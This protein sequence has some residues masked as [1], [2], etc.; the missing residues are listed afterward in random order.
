MNRFNNINNSAQESDNVSVTS[1]VMYQGRYSSDT[2]QAYDNMENY[3]K[4]YDSS[5]EESISL[6]S[7]AGN[8]DSHHSNNRHLKSL[9][10]LLISDMQSAEEEEEMRNAKPMCAYCGIDNPACIVKCVTCNKWFCNTR[11]G[12]SSSHIINHLVRSRHKIVQLHPNSELGEYTLECYNCGA[13]NVFVLG[14][15][16][17]KADTVMVILCRYPCANAPAQ[18]EMS[19]D[20]SKWTPLIVDRSFSSWL[21][22]A[23]SEEEL[24][25]ARTITPVQMIK[26]EEM[27]RDNPKATIEDLNRPEMENQIPQVSLRYA[28]GYEYQRCFAPLVMHEAEYDRRQK[29]AQTQSNVSVTWDMGL[30]RRHLVSFFLPDFETS[31]IRIMIGDEMAISYEGVDIGVGG[32]KKLK[33]ESTGFVIKVPS[34]SSDDVTLEL[35]PNSDPPTHI[36]SGYSIDFVWSGVTYERI[37]KALKEFAT[38]ETSVSGYLY[39]K[40]L[41]HDVKN[42]VFSHEIPT[43]F[44]VPGISALNPSQSAAVSSVLRHPLS[45]IQGPP[46]TGKT[47]VSTTIVYHI[48]K[49][50]KEAVLVCAP[51][52]VAADQLAVRLSKTGL[53]VIRLVAKSRETTLRDGEA[54]GFSEYGQDNAEASLIKNISLGEIIM[55]DPKT[56]IELKKLQQLK[57]DVG[58]LSVSDRKKYFDLL[59]KAEKRV[60]QQADVVCCT[61]AAAGDPRLKKIRFR[62]VLIDES[63]QA[64][65]PECL[66]PI[67][68]GCKQLVLVGDHQQLGPV[69]GCKA[70]ANA[71]LNRSLFER[72]I[73]LGYLPIRLTIQYRMHPCLS[74]FPSNMFYDG[75]LQNG[76]TRQERMRPDLNFP[77]PVPETPMMFW[78]ILGHEEISSSGTSY[79]NRSEATN[80]ER[81]VTRLFKAGVK[82]SQ[83]GIITPYEGQRAYLNQHMLNTGTMDREL[84]KGVE[85]ESVDAFQGREKDYIIVSCVR[86]NEHQGIGFLS[87]PRRLNVALT[88]AKF[89]LILLGNPRV[90]SKNVMW[91]HLLTHFREKGCLVEGVLSRLQPSSIQLSKPRQ[92]RKRFMN[93]SGDVS[94][95]GYDGYGQQVQQQHHQQ[96][97]SRFQPSNSGKQPPNFQY[98]ND[99]LPHDETASEHET[100]LESDFFHESDVSTDAGSDLESQ[101]G[102]MLD[103]NGIPSHISNFASLSLNGRG[104]VGGYA[105]DDEDSSSDESITSSGTIKSINQHYENH[106]NLLHGGES[107]NNNNNNNPIDENL[108]ASATKAFERNAHV[109]NNSQG[110]VTNKNSYI[111]NMKD[112]KSKKKNNT[113]VPAGQET[114]VQDRRIGNSFGDTLNFLLQK[115]EDEDEDSTDEE[116]ESLFTFANQNK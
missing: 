66:I 53:N 25:M 31:G 111:T 68:H 23:P 52:N 106:N 96:S 42:I 30:S 37:Q 33:W 100:N 57:D 72:F 59:K 69:I 116:Y 51:S 114:R 92:P 34:S 99:I 56:P 84:Y 80:C 21:I 46:G 78:S 55:N 2:R 35:T 15:I 13:Q 50:T 10:D 101:L 3:H 112:S 20:T 45:L 11:G 12:S 91:L 109:G 73:V 98:M 86:S 9:A 24:R 43:D 74:E 38:E 65:E 26:L 110:G 49:M 48:Q 36:T 103:V 18:K 22:S 64:T 85:I 108:I 113:V 89:G 29:E 6:V 79:L 7:E 67:V 97:L 41:G 107:N 83:I 8:Y 76:I 77:W 104:P 90:L 115:R 58:E 1:D 94:Q 19:W 87:D 82:P 47:V 105:G 63:T 17:A 62:T 14:F 102:D 54:A 16:A 5:D 61:C 32:T 81:V 75:S 95:Q 70:V 60:L 27:W 71:G 28:D 39:H 88:R 40:L 93:E 44:S 4:S